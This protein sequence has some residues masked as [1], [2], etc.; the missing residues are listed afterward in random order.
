MAEYK[1]VG[2]KVMGHDK[3]PMK[4]NPFKEL[5][6]DYGKINKLPM[7][8]KNTPKKAFEYNY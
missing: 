3:Q 1:A 8:Y 5:K 6:K 4:V 2:G 7:D